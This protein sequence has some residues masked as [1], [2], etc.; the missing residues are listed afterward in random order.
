MDNLPTM[1]EEM[2]KYIGKNDKIIPHISKWPI[3]EVDIKNPKGLW[4]N[5][6]NKLK[7]FDEKDLLK[8]VSIDRVEEFYSKNPDIEFE[9]LFNDEIMPKNFIFI[10]NKKVYSYILGKKNNRSKKLFYLR[11]FFDINEFF[12]C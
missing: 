3:F 2:C 5:F 7:E 11:F 9:V 1:N 12:N 8:P 4:Q 10:L 6:Q